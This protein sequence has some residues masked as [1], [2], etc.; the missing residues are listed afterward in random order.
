MVESRDE[1]NMA[2]LINEGQHALLAPQPSRTPHPRGLF[3]DTLLGTGGAEAG[4][5]EDK[6]VGV[7]GGGGGQEGNVWPFIH[8]YPCMF[9]F[10]S[11][12]CLAAS[13]VKAFKGTGS[14]Y[15]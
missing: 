13:F 15:V 11:V 3:T 14:V 9:P 8:L 1:S 5:G 12:G 4:V 6:G 7:G 10:T 2:K